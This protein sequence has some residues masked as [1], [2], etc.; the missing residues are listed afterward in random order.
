MIVKKHD[1]TNLPYS[2]VTPKDVYLNRRRFM[3]GLGAMGAALAAGVGAYQL[4]APGESVAAGEKLPFKPGPYGTTEE[5]TPLKD[6]TSY[7]NF[8]EFGTDKS[9]PARNAHTLK[10]RPW[11]V[12]VEGHVKKP[13]TLDI[14]NIMQAHALEERVYR[15]RCVEGWSMVIPGSASHWATSSRS[16]SPRRKPS[17]SSS[18][19]WSIPSRCPASA[20]LDRSVPGWSGRTQKASVW[21][22]Q[23]TRW[24]SSRWVFMVKCYPTRTARLS[25]WWCRGSMALRA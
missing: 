20:P 23:C 8:Y 12:R 6:I 13:M 22:K 18:T 7:N 21:M 14:D 11:T 10:P 17:S 16:W 19:R 4:L 2:E 3:T 5:K 1:N 15:L 25:A 9:D 24:P